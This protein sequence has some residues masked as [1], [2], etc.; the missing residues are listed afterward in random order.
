MPSPQPQTKQQLKWRLMHAKNSQD[1][2]RPDR[3]SPSQRADIKSSSSRDRLA[4][5]RKREEGKRKQKTSQAS[6][7]SEKLVKEI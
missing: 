5:T 1:L 7:V 6:S 3:S 4:W 2:S